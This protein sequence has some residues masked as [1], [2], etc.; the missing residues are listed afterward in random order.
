MHLNEMLLMST[1]SIWFCGEIK[2]KNVSIFFFFG[3]K[4]HLI[5]SYEKSHFFSLKVYD[6]YF[7]SPQKTYFIG[8]L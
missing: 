8:F 6:T 5:C 7:I 4:K 2:N 1:H 3:G